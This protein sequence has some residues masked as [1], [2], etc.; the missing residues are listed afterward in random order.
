VDEEQVR[1][2]AKFLLEKFGYDVL[3]AENSREALEIYQITAA[4]IILV[5]TDIGMPVMG[6][7]EL[8]YE[9]NNRYSNLPK[10]ISSRFGDVELCSRIEYDQIVG[11]TS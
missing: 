1:F 7:Y 10:I 9:L 11:I 4:G 6:G 8:C 3:E 2:I 5:L